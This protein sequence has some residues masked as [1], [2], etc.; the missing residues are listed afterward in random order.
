MT[1]TPQ[2]PIPPPPEVRGMT[3]WTPELFST[4]ALLPR[5]SVA[6]DQVSKIFS[7][8]L[9]NIFYKNISR[10][11]LG[12]VRKL[13]D[14]RLARIQGL[15]PIQESEDQDRKW[16]ILNPEQ[17]RRE[18]VFLNCDI[19]AFFAYQCLCLLAKIFI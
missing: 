5:I 6:T 13:L 16:L 8:Y 14:S 15:K 9:Q 3:E 17:V 1:F 4:S 11:Q 19:H 12:A 2:S 18:L 10:V 7:Q